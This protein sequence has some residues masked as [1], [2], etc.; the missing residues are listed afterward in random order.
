LIRTEADRLI[1]ELDVELALD[2]G[3]RSTGATSE[4]L[5]LAKGLVAWIA[6]EATAGR[7][8]DRSPTS[9]SLGY[10]VADGFDPRSTLAS[11]LIGFERS[12]GQALAGRVE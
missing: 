11:D 1:A 10:M 2:E 4:Q 9:G 6:D 7:R 12:V 5:S 8:P 3:G